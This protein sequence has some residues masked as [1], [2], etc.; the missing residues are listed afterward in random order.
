MNIPDLSAPVYLCCARGQQTELAAIVQALGQDG[1][2]SQVIE[3]GTEGRELGELVDATPGQALFVLCQAGPLDRAV[4]RKLEGMFSARCGPGHRLLVTMVDGRRPLAVLP[5]IRTAVGELTTHSLIDGE[6]PKARYRDVVGTTNVSAFGEENPDSDVRVPTDP[7]E[8]QG[9][10]EEL[11]R[12]FHAEMS[13]AEQLL[14]KGPEG[15]ATMPAPSSVPR[16]AW[17]TAHQSGVLSGS[18]PAAAR[19]DRV[20]HVPAT[21][22]QALDTADKVAAGDTAFEPA[23]TGATV[24]S[25]AQQ[26]GARPKLPL[27]LPKVV[28]GVVVALLMGM[29]AWQMWPQRS[30]ERGT[31]SPVVVTPA[32]GAEAGPEA[33]AAAAVDGATLGTTT[34]ASGE[35][36]GQAPSPPS[37]A[38]DAGVDDGEVK[39]PPFVSAR[40]D[41]PPPDPDDARAGRADGSPSSQ[42]DAIAAAIAAGHIRSLDLLLVRTTDEAEKSWDEARERCRRSGV[43]HIWNWRLPTA[44]ELR[45]LRLARMIPRHGQVW[46]SLRPKGDTTSAY[47]LD[48]DASRMRKL[49]RTSDVARF[50]CVR[51]RD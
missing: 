51:D 20:V 15:D 34:A 33:K 13:A 3:V 8:N 43:G 24:D 1:L 32:L 48:M 44:P 2:M 50:V 28:I 39:A 30:S 46:S 22:G 35:T 49:S 42:P 25:A 12:R 11:A 36:A 41:P 26:D 38:A 6:Q 10:V 5:R 17:G 31:P 16:H 21:H 47:A 40:N 19:D 9:D 4:A 29:L 18:A 7:S 27:W 14:S 23:D 37:M 45:K